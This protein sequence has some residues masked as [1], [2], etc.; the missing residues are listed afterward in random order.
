MSDSTNPKTPE[1][2]ADELRRLADEWAIARCQR[3]SGRGEAA[4]KANTR[5]VMAAEK[6]FDDALAALAKPQ[7]EPV[8]E[9]LSEQAIVALVL[10]S[11]ADLNAMEKKDWEGMRRFARLV[12]A[13]VLSARPVAQTAEPA[14]T[15]SGKRTCSP[16]AAASGHEIR[17]PAAVN[18][19]AGVANVGGANAGS[20]GCAR[21]NEWHLA[22]LLQRAQRH[23]V[24]LEVMADCADVI[25][26]ESSAL[27]DPEI[28][29][30]YNGNGWRKA[31]EDL[32]RLAAE[33]RAEDPEIWPVLCETSSQPT[34]PAETHEF[35][36]TPGAES[37][38]LACGW[39]KN[40]PSHSQPTE[41]AQP[42]AAEAT[43]PGYSLNLADNLFIEQR[44]D[45]V[46]LVCVDRVHGSMTSAQSACREWKARH[47]GKTLVSFC[48]INPLDPVRGAAQPMVPDSWRYGFRDNGDD[49]LTFQFMDEGPFVAHSALASPPAPAQPSTQAGEVVEC[50]VPTEQLEKRETT[51]RGYLWFSD[52]ENSAWT[53]LYAALPAA[54]VAALT[55][56]EIGFLVFRELKAN[57][58]PVI[59][60]TVPCGAELLPLCRAVVR[61]ALSA[62][63]PVQPNQTEGG[64]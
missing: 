41:P 13:E 48:G 35:E 52:P 39:A 5:K 60:S 10:K 40:H 51:T 1:A 24:V 16:K 28:D 22:T 64:V 33:I 8:A 17:D 43:K 55:D 42:V 36:P 4:F 63:L 34:E 45:G 12:E 15:V 30:P 54:P 23:P 62:S 20:C 56:E 38:C 37:H 11:G 3:V 27:N 29:G 14:E 57:D 2:L 21:P 32:R 61:A 44:G 6:A 18:A 46:W 59:S 58:Y 31:A 49:T 25:D 50:W 26:A 9:G 47:Q 7:A 53:P 19:A